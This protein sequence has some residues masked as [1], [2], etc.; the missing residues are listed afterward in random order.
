M[1]EVAV[2]GVGMTRFGVSENTNI[3]MFSEAAIK[4][5]NESNVKPKDIEA[6]FF[7]NALGTHEEGQM[8]MAAYAAADIGIPNIPTTRFEGVCATASVAIRDAFMWV[9]SGYYDMVLVGGTERASVMDTPY[10]TRTFAMGSDSYYEGPTG[11]TFP[12]VFA[13]L[14]HLYSH[15]YAIPL[16]K[17]KE[18]MAMVAIK[19]HQN[20]KFNP[21]AHF[22]ATIKDLME[23]RIARAS[24]KG[25]P[26]P[27]WADEMEF[28]ADTSVNPVIADP[29]Q[30][31][32]CCPFSDGAAALV[33]ASLDK[34]RKLTDKPV[35]IAGAGQCSAGPLHNQKDFTRMKARELSAKQAYAQAEI[36]PQDVGLCELHD[37]FTI[38]EIVA[39]ECLGFFE[40]GQ[41]GQAVERGETRIGG[42]IAINPSGGLKAKGHP[43]GATGAAQVY[44]VVN[45]LRGECG[46]RQVEGARIG[47]T[48]T[49]GGDACTICNIILKR[50]W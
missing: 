37:C 30:L 25:Q 20:G 17:L 48:D 33:L 8:G 12:G 39:T 40:F 41:G 22:Q 13:L 6:L 16:P 9:A 49:L 2:V 44:E 4:A 28:L 43:I 19:N 14:A 36:G 5:I 35:L 21:L 31:Y 10:A 11:I 27:G 15:K 47:M 50:G 46:K 29:L 1:R 42:K 24:Q 45:Q 34:A 18:Q 3:E 32:D 26:V 23:A 7:G 38:A